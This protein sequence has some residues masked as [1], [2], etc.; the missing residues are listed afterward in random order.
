MI[1]IFLALFSAFFESLKDVT[2]KKVLKNVDEYVA[3]F[4]LRF[5]AL[6][7][8][9]LVLVLAKIPTIQEGFWGALFLSGSLNFLATILY[10]KA[11]KTSDLSLTIPLVN[12]TP[13]FLL[14]T[15]PFMVGEFPQ[16]IGIIGIFTI[17][18][19][20]YLLNV[21]ER[22]KSLTA[23]FQALLKEKGPRLM[24]LV[25][26][27]WSISSNIQKIGVLNSSPVF[28]ALAENIFLSF[29][30]FPV[31][32]YKSPQGL[33]TIKNE[34]KSLFPI[35]FFSALVL[36]FQ[37]IAIG[38][39]LVVYV[40][41]IKRMSTLLSVLFGHFLFREKDVKQRLLGAAVMVLG[42]L[43]IALA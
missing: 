22:Q 20:A 3:A 26:F 14:I 35:G 4:S 7:V 23:P 39:T 34:I 10:M 18:V 30:L 41:S 24:L 16:T 1:G 33:R 19:G 32:L 28:Y 17:V 40:I 27:I 29:L 21:Q 5:F 9:L 25:A 2:S 8:L 37:M 36:T 42:V 43:L 31:M 15:S 13:L 12:F 6:P 38:L 11:I